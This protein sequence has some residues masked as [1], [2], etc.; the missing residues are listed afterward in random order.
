LCKVKISGTIKK[1]IVKYKNGR[2]IIIPV[3]K[4]M[5]DKNS[6]TKLKQKKVLKN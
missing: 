6:V 4:I 3:Q 1:G 2:A 5:V